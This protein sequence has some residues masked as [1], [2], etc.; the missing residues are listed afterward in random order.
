MGNNKD[1]SHKGH[2]VKNPRWRFFPDHLRPDVPGTAEGRLL[3]EL[4][5]SDGAMRREVFQLM[6]KRAVRGD[7]TANSTGSA[8]Y[9]SDAWAASGK[10]AIVTLDWN[11]ARS[12][13]ALFVK[14]LDGEGI[15]RDAL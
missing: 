8:L 6:T 2:T 5:L 7:F 12:P 9:D 15:G 1:D 3:W 13:S 14:W 10:P 4:P 11:D